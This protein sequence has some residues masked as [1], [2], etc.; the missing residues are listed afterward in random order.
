MPTLFDPIR[1]GDLDLANR[2]VMA[3][4]TR[5]RAAPGQ[6]PSDSPSSITH[7]APAPG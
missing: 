6:V 7:S 2:V 1:I 3:P 4:L 5:N